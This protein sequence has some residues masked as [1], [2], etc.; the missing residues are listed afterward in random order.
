M[1]RDDEF[2]SS[3]APMIPE[4]VRRVAR[5]SPMPLMICLSLTA[6]TNVSGTIPR[7][8]AL[9]H[10]AGYKLLRPGAV[11]VACESGFLPD[12]LVPTDDL[13]ARTTADLL[14]RD[15]EADAVVRARIDVTGWSIG[16][17]G[18]RC[19]RVEGD[20]VRSVRTILL[21]MADGGHGHHGH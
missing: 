20:V 12:A 19:V 16:L 3:M 17:Y 10:D 6:C 7:V 13:L 9:P 21:P 4:G 5:A 8:T 18:R 11:S 1:E 15:V 14:A 2:A